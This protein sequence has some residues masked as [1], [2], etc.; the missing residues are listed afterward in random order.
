M[1]YMGR[2]DEGECDPGDRAVSNILAALILLAVAVAAAVLVYVFAIGLIGSLQ[3]SGG[4][5]LLH[6]LRL[7]AYDWSACCPGTLILHVRNTRASDVVV[8]AVYLNGLPVDFDLGPCTQGIPVQQTCRIT[9]NNFGGA[10]TPGTSY[11]VKIVTADGAIFT[12]SAIAG[13]RS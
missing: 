1:S 5:Q 9:I 11:V 2:F 7:E 10:I 3:T 6:Q 4:Q 13:R 12:Y 8:A